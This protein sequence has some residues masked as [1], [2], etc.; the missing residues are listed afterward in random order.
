MESKSGYGILLLCLYKYLYFFVSENLLLFVSDTANLICFL[1]VSSFCIRLCAFNCFTWASLAIAFVSVAIWLAVCLSA[2]FAYLFGS[3]TMRFSNALWE[4]R[5]LWNDQ[6]IEFEN[7][8]KFMKAL[9]PD[10]AQ[11]HRLP[12]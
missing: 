12:E 5:Y 11:H 10:N 4:F 2:P 7:K 3:L 9:L 6:N 8:Q 1:G